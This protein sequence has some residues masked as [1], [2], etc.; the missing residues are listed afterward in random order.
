MSE[1]CPEPR[2][3]FDENGIQICPTCGKPVTNRTPGCNNCLHNAY[4]DENPF[5]PNPEAGYEPPKT[6]KE[7]S[8]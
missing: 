1:K 3:N 5:E 6:D 8:K 4:R 2:P 7:K